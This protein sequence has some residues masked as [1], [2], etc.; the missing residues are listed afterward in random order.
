MYAAGATKELPM[1]DDARKKTTSKTTRFQVLGKKKWGTGDLGEF[2][3]Y[4]QPGEMSYD[5]FRTFSYN[6]GVCT[7]AIGRF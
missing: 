7:A 6:W 5:T 1:S 2:Y 3:L 4:G